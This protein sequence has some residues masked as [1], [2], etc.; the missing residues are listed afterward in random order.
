M[1]I[2]FAAL[3]LSS[4]RAFAIVLGEFENI[5]T[6]DGAAAIQGHARL[7]VRESASEA[8]KAAKAE[9]VVFRCAAYW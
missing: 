1:F 8:L 9:F 5:F 3:A 6:H 2:C 7:E 4:E